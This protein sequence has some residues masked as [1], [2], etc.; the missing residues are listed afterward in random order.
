MIRFHAG[1]AFLKV[2][3]FSLREKD[4][5]LPQTLHLARFYGVILFNQFLHLFQITEC[6]VHN[7][8]RC[9]DSMSIHQTRILLSGI[10]SH[11]TPIAPSRTGAERTS[12]QNGYRSSRMAF[13]QCF[14]HCQTGDARPNN[15]KILIG[16]Q[17]R[18]L[19]VRQSMWNV[20]PVGMSRIW[21]WQAWI[22]R[23]KTGD[24]FESVSSHE[25]GALADFI[26]RPG[27]RDEVL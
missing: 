6:E 14:S 9:F 23:N 11:L 4:S 7:L 1:N 24:Y 5:Q 25:V 10:R 13:Q 17:L 20:L 16:W 12:L 3:K 18:G 27:M 21:S 15:S 8:A 26:R 22:R 19:D 2:V